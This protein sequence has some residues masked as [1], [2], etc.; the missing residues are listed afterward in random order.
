MKI[1][2][3]ISLHGRFQFEMK[4]YY[5]FLTGKKDD[6]FYV[7]TYFFIPNNLNMNEET[8]QKQD[9]YADLHTYIRLRTPTVS[10][11]DLAGQNDPLGSLKNRISS[12]SENY[13][14]TELVQYED[15]VK[16]FC[17]TLKRSLRMQLASI[18]ES[19]S[20][21]EISR[22]IE[23]Y[24]KNIRI[25]LECFRNPDGITGLSINQE[26]ASLHLFADE[27]I[28]LK[29]ES[30]T[31][32]LLEIIKNTKQTDRHKKILLALINR[33]IQHR[34]SKGYPSIPSGDPLEEN[35][36]ARFIFRQGVLK[37]YISNVLFLE[38]RTERGGKYLEQILYSIS[39]GVAMI[40]ATAVAFIGQDQYGNLSTPFFIALV[41]SYM[42]KDRIKE[43]LRI[44][45]SQGMRKW[46]YDRKKFIYHRFQTK[47]G[48]CK[49][50]FNYLQESKV[51]K[52]ILKI[53]KK[54]IFSNIDNSLVG[55][56]IILYRKYIKLNSRVSRNIKSRYRTDGIIDIVRFNVEKFLR[57]IDDPE[58]KL[59]I[60]ERNDY[61]VIR[62]ERVYHLNIITHYAVNSKNQY[63]KFRV[64]YNRNGIISIKEIPQA[65]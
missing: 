21:K 12:L 23:D 6:S 42:F 28:S 39:A 24:D 33:E 63:T 15:E 60:A 54:D 26:V 65:S 32:R 4:Q 52:E 64:I 44:Y 10:L 46:L 9:F 19:S 55:E 35:K 2:E 17:L 22:L 45:F 3:K 47:I 31:F 20:S 57:Y 61:S 34:K 37:K 38:T 25:L 56:D 43:L 7:K 59:F 11:A 5:S 18:K 29:I 16:L 50:S 48:V 40:F 8:Y 49:E 41:I 13:S 53:R 36:N 30:H 58:K 14:E 51:P 1:E 27:Y 62:G